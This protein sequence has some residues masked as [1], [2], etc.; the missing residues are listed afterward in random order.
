MDHRL[1]T[2]NGMARFETKPGLFST[3]NGTRISQFYMTVVR[4]THLESMDAF[5]FLLQ[6]LV[7]HAMLLHG[8]HSLEGLTRDDDLVERPTTA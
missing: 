2:D 1:L 4:N 3:D 5:Y 6:Y 7:H 8:R